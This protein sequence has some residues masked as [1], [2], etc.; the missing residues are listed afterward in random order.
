MASSSTEPTGSVVTYLR[1]ASNLANVFNVFSK[2]HF[3]YTEGSETSY[4]K[5]SSPVVQKHIQLLDGIALLFVYTPNHDIVATGLT[6]EEDEYVIHWA[7]NFAGHP[8][9]EERDYLR[10]LGE[11]FMRRDNPE[12]ILDTVV[13]M[14][15]KK[16]NN[17][18]KNIKRAL[19]TQN[20][21]SGGNNAFDI[22]SN[23]PAA[24]R[25][26][27]YLVRKG[28]TDFSLDKVLNLLAADVSKDPNQLSNRTV[29]QLISL[30]YALSLNTA[31]ETL[32]HV[33]SCERYLLRKIKKLGSYYQTC[34]VVLLELSKGVKGF[35]IQQVQAPATPDVSCHS[36]LF[37]SLNMWTRNF[38]YDEI[39]RTMNVINTYGKLDFGVLGTN[40]IKTCQHCELTIGLRLY[41]RKK[42]L[43]LPGPVEVGCSK[44]S[45]LYCSIY[46]DR[47][48]EWEYSEELSNRTPRENL[49]IVRGSH[50]KCILG[51]YMPA[52]YD[53]VRNRVLNSIGSM[54]T[55]IVDRLAGPPRRK[56]DSR[57]PPDRIT[58]DE[59]MIERA[60]NLENHRRSKY[61]A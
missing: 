60:S 35:R 31:E 15:R 2:I 1:D 24:Q 17:R 3:H 20:A 52:N 25:L 18:I 43:N 12:E 8:T 29:V 42:E 61:G 54:M 44:A 26:H 50:N 53:N 56:S 48:N 32:E 36:N 10:D 23:D 11:S 21:A 19:E 58:L 30:A 4:Y 39:Q 6:K 13:P 40:T 7:K 45:C 5:N 55:E 14:C 28:V 27:Q 59:A 51:W 9:K 49:I 57:S 46:L 16:I 47:F 37:Q 22:N 41:E 38:G 34:L 33:V